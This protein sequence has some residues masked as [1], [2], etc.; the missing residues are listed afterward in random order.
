MIIRNFKLSDLDQVLAIE[1]DSFSDAYP[2]GILLELYN[3]GVGFLVAE[4]ANRV[5]GYI[6]FWIRNGKGHIIAIA[7]DENFRDMHIGSLLLERT[8][9]VFFFN[10]IFT[11]GL[12]VRKSNV[13]AR[14]FYLK[15]G[16]VEVSEEEG[17]YSDGE[18]A[19]LMQYNK[20]D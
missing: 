20:S 3:S 19:I 8:L 17:Y 18:N 2:V 5:V 10:K 14:A 7:V 15:R 9:K 12:E 11:I 13:S 16:F 1:Y 4:A 6:I